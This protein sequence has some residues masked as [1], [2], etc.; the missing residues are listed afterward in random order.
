MNKK[1]LMITAGGIF[2]LSLFFLIFSIYQIY[3]SA[4]ETRQ[5]LKEWETKQRSINSEQENPASLIDENKFKEPRQPRSSTSSETQPNKFN[6]H[7]T[8][9]TEPFYPSQPE[10]GD[11]FGKLI[12]PR[13]DKQLPIIAGTGYEELKKGV[14]HYMDSVLPGQNNNTVLAGHR[15]GVFRGLGKLNPGDTVTIKTLAGTFTYRILDHQIVEKTDLSVVKPQ[16]KPILT[17]I[18]CYPFNYVGNAPKRYIL[19]A[20][21]LPDEN[22][23][24][25]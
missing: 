25:D 17:M 1:W 13:L 22:N 5:A 21:L 24:T 2:F 8:I 15:D 18:T 12:I 3:S 23:K 16:D 4:A 20:E 19:T 6:R 10:K 9:S 7:Q 14:G 11:V